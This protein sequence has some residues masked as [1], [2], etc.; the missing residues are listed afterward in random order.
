MIPPAKIYFYFIR[1]KKYPNVANQ[2]KLL[3][4]SANQIGGSW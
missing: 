3:A 1:Q 2:V 4:R